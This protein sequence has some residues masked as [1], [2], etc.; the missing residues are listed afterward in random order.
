MTITIT[1]TDGTTETY[2]GCSCYTNDG[3]FLRFK[4]KLSGQETAVEWEI[5][6]DSVRKVR[7][8]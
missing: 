2:T 6:C 8:E 1:Y 3:D 4:G 5:N 7:R